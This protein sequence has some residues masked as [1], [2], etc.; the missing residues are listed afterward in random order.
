MRRERWDIIAVC[1]TCGLQ[2]QADLARIEL[3]KGPEFSLWDRSAPCR[4][5]RCPGF[6]EFHAKPPN[7]VVRFRMQG[8][9][10]KPGRE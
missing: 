7:S 5:L 1:Q 2:M 10:V 8:H 3:E 9:P 4:R 6:V